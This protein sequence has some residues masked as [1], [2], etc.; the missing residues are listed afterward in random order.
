M[1]VEIA[2]AY[3]SIIPSARGIEEKLASEFRKAGDDAARAFERAFS[4][5]VGGPNMTRAADDAGDKVGRRFGDRFSGGVKLAVGVATAAIATLGAVEVFRFGA[6]S[7]NAFTSIGESVNKLSVLV[8]DNAASI[9]EW[10][11]GTATSIGIGQAKALDAAGVYANL[12]RTIGI[13]ADES[14]DLSTRLVDLSADLASFNNANPEDVLEALRSGLTGE[15]EPLRRF[16]VFLSEATVKAKAMEMGLSDGSGELTEA[17]KL[18]A[19]YALILE[20]TG[21]AQGDFARTSDSAAN[22]QRILAARF[23]DLKVKIGQAVAPLAEKLL[24]ALEGLISFAGEV[25]D[26]F[27][28]G[29]FSGVWELIG[30]KW[31]EAWPTIQAKLGEVW[32]GIVA[33]AWEKVQQIPAVVGALATAFVQW[34]GT[35]WDGGGVEGQEGLKPKLDAWIDNLPTWVSEAA[36]KVGGY[37]AGLFGSFL[38]WADQLWEGNETQEGL[39]TKLSAALDKLPGWVMERLEAMRQAVAQFGPA[40]NDWAD[41]LWNGNEATGDEGL[42]AKLETLMDDFA[43]W[44]EDEGATTLLWNAWLLSLA[45]GAGLLLMPQLMYQALGD[46]LIAM[47]KAIPGIAAAAWSLGTRLAASFIVGIGDLYE[48]LPDT[49]KSFLEF[50]IPGLRQ[51]IRELDEYQASVELGNSSI[52]TGD[53]GGTVP[54]AR[55]APVLTLLHGGETV[56]PTHRM[57]VNSAASAVGIGTG[58]GFSVQQSIVAPDPRRAGIESARQMRKQAILL[59]A[60]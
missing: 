26:A 11:R 58:S 40:F 15:V 43:R 12:F 44:V 5:N 39:K 16:G 4:S 49:L 34:A 51:G 56:L 20:Q 25:V 37:M 55:G 50:V 21:A 28:E 2:S 19:R 9:E 3:V 24:P 14:A 45:F 60:A 38:D 22:Q 54:G 10:S 6:D 53:A 17:A 42:K 27:T 32:D 30:E 1:A 46:I 29:G 13:G 57:P 48:R 36:M 18:Q 41:K 52:P 8:G 23:D 35:L 59:G 33:W 7:F 31:N 47:V